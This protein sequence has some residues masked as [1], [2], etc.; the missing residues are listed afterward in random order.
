M[1]TKRNITLKCGVCGNE[2]FTFDEKRY[3][4]INEADEVRCSV[5]NKV[6]TGD[7][8]QA[9]NSALIENSIEEL[10]DEVIEKA[11][12]KSGFKYRK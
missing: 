3:N 9:V 8:L 10:A 1:D 6:Y 12:K 2:N 5:C 7:E 11:L 4:S